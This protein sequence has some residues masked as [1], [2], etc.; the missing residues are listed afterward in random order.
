MVNFSKR[1]TEKHAVVG[2]DS[3]EQMGGGQI[4]LDSGNNVGVSMVHGL[5]DVTVDPMASA[6]IFELARGPKA[7]GSTTTFRMMSRMMAKMSWI[8]KMKAMTTTTTTTTMRIRGGKRSPR[9]GA[10]RRAKP[11][12]RR[13]RK[14]RKFGR[15]ERFVLGCGFRRRSRHGR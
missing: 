15:G 11:A 7:T 8:L 5:Q 2:F 9:G 1:G 4:G 13:F 6:A 14:R 3:G 10:R 12:R